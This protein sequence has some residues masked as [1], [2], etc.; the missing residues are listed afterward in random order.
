M[1]LYIIALRVQ[2][3]LIVVHTEG[4]M[5]QWVDSIEKILGVE[6]ADVGRICEGEFRI[7]D[8]ITVG[9]VQTVQKRAQEI[10]PYIGQ[11]VM[12]ECHDAPIMQY[13]KTVE[14][15]DCQY[16]LG[17]NDTPYRRD[18]LE[19]VL[20]W[21]IGPITGQVD[22]QDIMNSGNLNPGKAVLIPTGFTPDT[23]PSKNYG[24]ALNEMTLDLNR[25]QFIAITILKYKCF[26]L[27]LV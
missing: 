19:Q 5:D 13:V 20:Q 1:A 9:M 22:E 17:L 2:P 11:L 10:S 7:G 23:D 18:G 21:Y 16:L 27:T 12:D 25:N 4:L 26:G 3:T 8:Q 14:Q 6:A 24:N 15:F